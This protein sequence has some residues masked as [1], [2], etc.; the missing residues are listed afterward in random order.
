MLL[1]KLTS[2]WSHA[3]G[4]RQPAEEPGGDSVLALV[5][6]AAESNRGSN[7]RRAIK[8]RL[9]VSVR[10]VPLCVRG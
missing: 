3:A 10:S 6:L 8:M 1:A 9:L 5:I 2:R 4:G 7:H